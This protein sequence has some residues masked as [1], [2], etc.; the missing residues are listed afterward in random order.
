MILT[1]GIFWKK[2][3]LCTAN[4]EKK[5]SQNSFAY[6][7]IIYYNNDKSFLVLV[8]YNTVFGL[9]QYKKIKL[10]ELK[11][12]HQTKMCRIQRWSSIFVLGTEILFLGKFGQN[13]KIIC[14]CEIWYLD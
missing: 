7:F 14:S 11:F 12:V 6:Q 10:P 3:I 2:K 13:I 4:T 9:I 1:V 5:P 8:I